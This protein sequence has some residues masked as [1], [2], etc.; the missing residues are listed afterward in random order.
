LSIIIFTEGFSV[1]EDMS[2]RHADACSHVAG[3]CASMEHS[4]QKR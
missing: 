4:A 3:A 2:V 1:A